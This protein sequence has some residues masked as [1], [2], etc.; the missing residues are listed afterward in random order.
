VGHPFHELLQVILVLRGGP[1]GIYTSFE[2]LWKGTKNLEVSIEKGQRK[3]S[4]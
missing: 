1:V 4:R 3:S 2:E